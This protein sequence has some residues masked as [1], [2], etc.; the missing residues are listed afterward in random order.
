MDVA[1][2]TINAMQIVVLGKLSIF[3]GHVM[4]TILNKSEHPYLA[5]DLYSVPRTTSVVLGESHDQLIT[6]RYQY[7]GGGESSSIE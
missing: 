3:A 6:N 7:C 1:L 2:P 4:I 5:A